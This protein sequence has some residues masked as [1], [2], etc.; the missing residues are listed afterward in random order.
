[1][2]KP[3]PYG[4]GDPAPTPQG[5]PIEFN[6]T[7]VDASGA[8][9]D[10]PLVIR[11][12]AGLSGTVR[13][14]NPANFYNGPALATPWIGDVE[15]TADGFAPWTTGANPQ[16]SFKDQTVNVQATLTPSF[17]RPP[18]PVP[19]TRGP[20]P[21]FS[22]IYTSPY[23]AGMDVLPWAPPAVR[24]A[25]D[26]ASPALARQYGARLRHWRPGP[27]ASSASAAPTPSYAPHERDYLRADSWGVVMPGAP[28]IDRGVS[29]THPER[30]MSWFIDRYPEDFQHEYLSLYG[31]YGYTHLRLSYADSTAAID[32]PSNKPP[33]AGRTLDQFIDTCLLVKRYIPYVRVMIGSKYFQPGFM[34]ASQWAEF[35]DPIIDA[36]IAAKAVD[37]ITLGWEWN[38]WNTPGQVTIDSFRHCGQRAHAAGLSSWM[39]FAPHVTSWFADGDPRGRFGFYDDLHNDVN[40]IDY[41]TDPSW[42]MDET[43]ARLVDTLWQF[44]DRGN[45]YK[46]R[47]DEDMATLMWSNDRPD[48][49]DANARGYL[50]CCTIDNVHWTDAKIWGFGNGG[51]M[52]DGSRI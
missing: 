5:A 15:V 38:L 41:Q 36:L 48:S 13:A 50:A 11:I 28:Q 3:K 19:V 37:E 1:M 14:T 52:P 33:G 45:D 23:I 42:P 7:V 12:D 18:S 9:I 43:Q 24:A 51:R 47:F 35:S 39:H 16:I 40:G 26:I 30:I 32:Q 34:T 25:D 20:L 4:G 29:P 31:G 6:V 2:T 46:M 22:P 44:G 8:K 10:K 17:K 27:S 21:P 49:E